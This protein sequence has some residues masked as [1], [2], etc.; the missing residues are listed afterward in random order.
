MGLL[1][2]VLNRL[3]GAKVFST[4]DL[5]SGYLQIEFS[6]ESRKLTAF[7]INNTRYEWRH[8][9][10]GLNNAVSTYARLMNTVLSGIEGV[11]NFLDD[12]L[13]YSESEEQHAEILKKVLEIT[14]TSTGTKLEEV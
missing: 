12:I 9:P 8:M 4:L 1:Q 2:T 11:T 10:F 3:K 6:P 14:G 13:I 7:T 5:E